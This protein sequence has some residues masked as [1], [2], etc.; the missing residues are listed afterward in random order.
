MFEFPVGMVFIYF[1]YGLAFFSMGLAILL[2]IGRAPL[3]AEAKVLRPL[4]V[5]GLL[6]GTH[7]WL[8]IFLLQLEWLGSALPTFWLWLRLGLL[9]LSFASLAAYGVQVLY[10]PKRLAAMDTWVGAGL[11]T[12]YTAV[13]LLTGTISW[14]DI[15]I[16]VT[17]ADVLARYLLAL[18]GAIVATIALF[19]QAKQRR[20]DGQADLSKTFVWAAWGFAFYGVSQFFV[21]PITLFPANILNT[22]LFLGVTGIPVQVI[23]AIIAVLITVSL[24][25]AMQIVEKQR[26][27]A[28]LTAQQDRLVA[29]EQVQAELLKRENMQRELLRHTVI[30]QEDERSRI[31]R[32]LHDETAQILTAFSLDVATLKSRSGD[33]PE[34]VAISNR[35][36][37]LSKNLSRSLKRLVHDLRPAQLDDLGIIPALNYLIDENT[38]HAGL[39]V[40]MDIQG[41]QHRLDPLVETVLYRVAQ[42]ALTNIVRH[43]QT[44]KAGLTLVYDQ[45]NVSLGVQ[46]HGVG[47]LVDKQHPTQVGWGIAGM[48]ER[49]NS[50]GGQ[51]DLISEPEQG[52]RITVVIPVV[53]NQPKEGVDK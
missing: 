47:F 25:Q 12:L 7:E 37:T 44:K 2:E 22:Q 52:T 33:D 34:A 48:R 13:V 23:R 9:A 32:E 35:L 18:P 6:H 45:N 14:E 40:Q 21:P 8:E 43:A 30:A 38:R 39:Q 49:V 26:Q 36:Q 53:L 41:V 29:L 17:Q 31:S 42:E 16:W 4:A 46:D 24:I 28:L 20:M 3:L 1:I 10:P 50:V 15:Q 51:F 27:Q 5:F 19:A 11:L